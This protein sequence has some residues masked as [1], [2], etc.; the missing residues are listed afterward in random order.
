MASGVKEEPVVGDPAGEQ[1][2]G[3]DT[4]LQQGMHSD[5]LSF[6]AMSM[7]QAS[8]AS[9]CLLK[10]YLYLKGYLSRICVLC[11][12]RLARRVLCV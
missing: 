8:E 3:G 4:P 9:A 6:L 2:V 10:G 11:V 1:R 5:G 12:S 7:M